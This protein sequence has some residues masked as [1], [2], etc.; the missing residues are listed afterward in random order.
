MLRNAIEGITK[1]DRPT[2]LY[3]EMVKIRDIG[4]NLRNLCFVT[5]ELQR[6][7]DTI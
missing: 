3:Y 6:F 5:F 2:F 1:C 4:Q 7:V